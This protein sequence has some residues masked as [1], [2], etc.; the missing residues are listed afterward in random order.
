MELDILWASF[1][2]NLAW[3]ASFKSPL[4]PN[5]HLALRYMKCSFHQCGLCMIRSSSSNRLRL[6]GSTSWDTRRSSHLGAPA[7]RTFP[8]AQAPSL[9]SS[10]LDGSLSR[11]PL[12]SENGSDVCLLNRLEEYSH[13][14]NSSMHFPVCSMQFGHEFPT[15]CIEDVSHSAVNSSRRL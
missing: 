13:L 9:E 5:R 12:N 4:E 2:T 11:P 8:R 14:F 7:S 1:R 3:F 6:S 10:C 15:R